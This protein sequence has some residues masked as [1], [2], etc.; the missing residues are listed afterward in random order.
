MHIVNAVKK[1]ANRLANWLRANASGEIYAAAKARKLLKG[2]RGRESGK[3][4][5]GIEGVIQGAGRQGQL[6][7]K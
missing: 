3:D 6:T 7:A 4:R 2:K 1:V 5:S